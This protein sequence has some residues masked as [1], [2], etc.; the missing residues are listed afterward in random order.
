MFQFYVPWKRQKT[1]GFLTFLGGLEIE[2]WDKICY[3]ALFV[4][5]YRTFKQGNTLT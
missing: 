3:F 1:E 5:E 2:H 4:V